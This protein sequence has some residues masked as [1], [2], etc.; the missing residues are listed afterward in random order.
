MYSF[1]P[2]SIF[3]QNRDGVA[4]PERIV[5]GIQTQA[6]VRHGPEQAIEFFRS[7]HMGRHMMMESH[8]QPQSRAD[9]DHFANG[10]LGRFPL[11]FVP[12]EPVGLGPPSSN[13][14]SLGSDLI[15][16]DEHARASLIEQLRSSL[17]VIKSGVVFR[18]ITELH[19]HKSRAES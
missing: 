19:G 17:T 1:Y 11:L 10:I 8:F 16:K 4:A 9:L 12:G 13:R 15:G 18:S 14:R 6:E 7:F 5:T 3:L 2:L